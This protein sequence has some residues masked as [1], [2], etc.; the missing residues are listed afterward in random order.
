[1]HISGGKEAYA[2]SLLRSARICHSACVQPQEY[3]DRRFRPWFEWPELQQTFPRVCRVRC[4]SAF[5]TQRGNL[6]SPL[7]DLEKILL[8]AIIQ[9]RGKF[10]DKKRLYARIQRTDIKGIPGGW[11]CFACR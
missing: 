2:H 6:F 7:I 3:L 1:M 9:I 11:E 4:R 8:S 5:Q 10:H